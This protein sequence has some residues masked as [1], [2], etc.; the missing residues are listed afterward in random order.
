[1]C[2]FQWKYMYIRY[3][4]SLTCCIVKV[5]RDKLNTKYIHNKSKQFDIQQCN[6]YDSAVCVLRV[7][8]GA[9][10]SF[11]LWQ[12]ILGLHLKPLHIFDHV[13]TQRSLG[14]MLW[15][16][17]ENRLRDFHYSM[18]VTMFGVPEY[19]ALVLCA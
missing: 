13:Y 19:W 10:T 1:M 9:S 4:I 15:F 17:W 8:E 14:L 5:N 12:A 2:P 18:Y 7:P 11:L 6:L 3:K 16:Q